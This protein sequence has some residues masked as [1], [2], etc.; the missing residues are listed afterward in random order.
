M[1]IG[2]AHVQRLIADALDG[3]AGVGIILLFVHVVVLWRHLRGPL[4]KPTVR[5]PISILKPLCGLDDRLLQNLSTFADL[6][7]PSYEVLLGLRDA[8][9][10]AYETARSVARRWPRRFRVVLQSGEP[11][12]NPKVN[13]AS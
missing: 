8:D 5:P 2:V 7:Y 12:L 10:A 1:E 4:P 13:Q 9:D 11:G 6:P 3:A